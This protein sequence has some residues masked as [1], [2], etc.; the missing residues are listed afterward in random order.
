M[1]NNQNLLLS[2]KLGQH[3]PLLSH[4]DNFLY[5]VNPICHFSGRIQVCTFIPAICCKSNLIF[6]SMPLF[7]TFPFQEIKVW[8]RLLSKW[9]GIVF[10][11]FQASQGLN[12]RE[13][14]VRLLLTGFCF[15]AY[16]QVRPF[17]N[18][19]AYIEFILYDLDSSCTF[20]CHMLSIAFYFYKSIYSVPG[21][22]TLHLIFWCYSLRKFPNLFS[23]KKYLFPPT[24]PVQ[25]LNGWLP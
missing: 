20:H 18:V 3:K 24:K 16:Q 19:L 1:A 7:F 23:N 22:T 21:E 17:I 15:H 9:H 8:G 11:L 4:I 25:L 2:G 5:S 10:T 6:R 12:I 13:L 14:C